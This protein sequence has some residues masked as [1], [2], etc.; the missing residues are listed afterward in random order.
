MY[1]F[2]R[3]TI[4]STAPNSAIL[5]KK[6]VVGI[7]VQCKTWLTAGNARKCLGFALAHQYWDAMAWRRVIFVDECSVNTGK[8]KR[9]F[10]AGYS[11]N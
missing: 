7:R 3:E 11:T 1:D 5:H 10:G 8:G 2:I 4:D 6:A 9:G